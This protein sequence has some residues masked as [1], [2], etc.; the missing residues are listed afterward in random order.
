M[1][2]STM[3]TI[4]EIINIGFN[5]HQAGK[6]EQAEFA[7]MEALKLDCENPE[8]FNLIGVLKLQQMIL[9]LQLII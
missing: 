8:L 3:P 7:Y 1:G 9:N 6:L 2:V 5:S 4:D